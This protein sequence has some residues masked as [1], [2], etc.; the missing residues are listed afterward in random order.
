LKINNFLAIPIFVYRFLCNHFYRKIRLFEAYLYHNLY[1]YK[2]GHK[3]ELLDTYLFLLTVFK[4]DK[5]GEGA[6]FIGFTLT[7]YVKV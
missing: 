1:Q 7:S 3:V 2:N 6:S 4:G 5:K